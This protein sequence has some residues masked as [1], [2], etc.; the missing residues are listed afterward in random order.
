MVCRSS[1]SSTGPIATWAKD[2]FYP[3]QI[4]DWSGK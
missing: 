2:L 1:S 4:P 3:E